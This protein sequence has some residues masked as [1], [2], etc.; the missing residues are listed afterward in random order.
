MLVFNRKLKS[1]AR[2]KKR[3]LKEN[4]YNGP[5]TLELCYR[6]DY[7]NQSISDF[8]KEGFNRG[9]KLEEIYKNI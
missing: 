1:N 8:Y 7:L 4:N 9:L 5:I 6:Y 2:N 3:Q